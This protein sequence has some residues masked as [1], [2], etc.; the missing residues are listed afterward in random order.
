MSS[1]LSRDIVEMAR[2]I[3]EYQIKKGFV[4]DESKVTEQLLLIHAEVSEATEEMRFPDF[5]LHEVR[6]SEDGKITGFA[7]EIAD[8][9][10]RTLGM[11]EQLNIPIYEVM[12]RKHKY[13]LTRPFKNGKTF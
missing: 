10:I 2:Q 13:N 5:D 7:S 11:A 6:E 8:I 4:I 3:A 12:K 9:L 1:E